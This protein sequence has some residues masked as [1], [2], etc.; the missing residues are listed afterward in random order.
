MWSLGRILLI[1]TACLLA[2]GCTAQTDGKSEKSQVRIESP[3]PAAGVGLSEIVRGKVTNL[4]R[5]A[6]VYVLVHPLSMNL[7]WVQRLPSPPNADGSW[8][9]QC[10]FGTEK[11]GMG[12]SFELVAIAATSRLKEGQTL[13]EFPRDV[14]RSDVVTVKRVR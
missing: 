2:A 5:K 9:T 8:Q 4:D 10:Y 14:A 1:A 7:W 13:G 11:E 6:S 12:E 3:Q